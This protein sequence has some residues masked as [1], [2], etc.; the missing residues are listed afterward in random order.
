MT[1]DERLEIIAGETIDDL[2]GTYRDDTLFRGCTFIGTDATEAKII[3]CV[4]ER[5]TISSVKFDRA[6]LQAEFRE[7]KVEG[8]NFFMAQRT[9]LSIHFKNCII[10]H[11]SF[12][13]LKLRNIS[14][15]GCT[16]TNVDFAEADIL[17]ANFSN[18]KFDGC[19]FQSTN[20]AQANFQ[21]AE[22]YAI[23]PTKNKLVGARFEMPEV[24]ALLDVFRI[25]I[26]G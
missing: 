19:I 3:D 20:L 25:E 11:S 1:Q 26:T 9:L 13:T 5:C 4:F 8:V 10:R 23:D 7:C 2:A 14:F 12:A 22:G 6:R 17:G 21:G 18:V 15:E 16:L 24:M